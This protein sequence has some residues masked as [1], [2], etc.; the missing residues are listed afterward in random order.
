MYFLQMLVFIFLQLSLY[1]SFSIKTRL[2][3]WIFF[4]IFIFQLQTRSFLSGFCIKQ[5]CETKIASQL[6]NKTG[7]KHGLR[8]WLRIVCTV[9]LL[10]CLL[11]LVWPMS[12]SDAPHS[13]SPWS[14]Q[15]Q[16][17]LDVASQFWSQPFRQS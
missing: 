5:F 10:A 17:H 9:Y 6:V 1:L 4:L 11:V 13:A 7:T 12:T 14:G 3:L 16:D 15:T 2:K 8:R